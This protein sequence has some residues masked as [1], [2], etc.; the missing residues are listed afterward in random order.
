MSE[1]V[2]L[3]RDVEWVVELAAGPE[4]FATGPVEVYTETEY[5]DVTGSSDLGLALAQITSRL[6]NVLAAGG[7]QAL[8]KGAANP[9]A[10]IMGAD[11]PAPGGGGP[12]VP[13][14]RVVVVSATGRVLALVS[15]PDRSGAP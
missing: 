7:E 11:D 9:A 5:Q 3:G 4:P 15:L 2:G 12:L 8:Y 1:L 10:E 14:R 13:W 6:L